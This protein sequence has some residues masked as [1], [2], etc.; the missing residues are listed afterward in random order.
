MSDES[1][2]KA[3]KFQR[4]QSQEKSDPGYQLPKIPF[5]AFLD[6]SGILFVDK[7]RQ[8]REGGGE[9]HTIHNPKRS[10]MNW[11]RGW[12]SWRTIK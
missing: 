7:D 2:D 6:E 9:S 8:A 12:E 1:L 4:K 5:S 11:Q 3:L 10:R